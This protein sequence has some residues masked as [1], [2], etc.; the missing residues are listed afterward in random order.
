MEWFLLGVCREDLAPSGLS[1]LLQKAR[2]K[3]IE[4]E[5]YSGFHVSLEQ[6]V[7]KVTICKEMLGRKVWGGQ[8]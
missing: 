1:Y 8:R 3:E 2:S 6:T 4:G 7:G 5:D